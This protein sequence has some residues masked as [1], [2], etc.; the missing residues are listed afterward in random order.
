MLFWCVF[1]YELLMLAKAIHIYAHCLLNACMYLSVHCIVCA[2]RLQ[3]YEHLYRLILHSSQI[4][5]SNCARTCSVI[6]ILELNLPL[7]LTLL[8]YFLTWENQFK[9][10]NSRFLIHVTINCFYRSRLSPGTFLQILCNVRVELMPGLWRPSF[11]WNKAITPNHTDGPEDN[12]LCHTTKKTSLRCFLHF[13][14]SQNAS[15]QLKTAVHVLKHIWNNTL[16]A[17]H[18]IYK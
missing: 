17:S 6:C 3:Q 16:S 7:F 10:H 5:T 9:P 11:R 4:V 1:T 18:S 15:V 8:K 2:Y 12:T 13:F 14:F